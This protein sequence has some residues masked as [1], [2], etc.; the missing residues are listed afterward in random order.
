M[1]YSPNFYNEM[2][3]VLGGEEV[4][5]AP[6][7]NEFQ[8]HDL[9]QK[10]ISPEALRGVAS[11]FELDEKG[12]SAL[13]DTPVHVGFNLPNSS[14]AGAKNGEHL[15]RRATE[16]LIKLAELIARGKEVFESEA[17]FKRWLNTRIGA[18]WGKKPIEYVNT[19]TGIEIVLDELGRIEHGIHS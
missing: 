8:V 7:R 4:V 9:A 11:F 5:G 15:A 12:M 3:A 1:G 6:M 16:H 13:L 10:G 17:S 2:V 19:L 18:F 14:K